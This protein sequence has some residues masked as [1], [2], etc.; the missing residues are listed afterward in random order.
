MKTYGFLHLTISVKDLAR[1]TAFYRDV[2]NC[3]IVSSNPIM[4]FMKSGEDF[5]VLTQLDHHVSPNSPGAPD[6]HSTLFHHAMLIEPSAFESVREHL[7]AHGV[8]TFES[9]FK[10][11]TFPD[12]RHL[13]IKDPDGNSIELVTMSPA[14]CERLLP[15]ASAAR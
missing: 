14:E 13:Y 7:A 11:S 5:F 4:T 8:A 10:H 1:A 6:E 15:A 9:D 12:R 2:L 3:E